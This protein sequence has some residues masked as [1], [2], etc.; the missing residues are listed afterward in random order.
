MMYRDKVGMIW[1]KHE[2][3]LSIECN[4]REFLQV[5]TANDSEP[6]QRAKHDWKRMFEF[7]LNHM[8]MMH[9]RLTK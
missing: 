6:K 3:I 2:V 9:S 7:G 5:I 8:K 1:M 4:T